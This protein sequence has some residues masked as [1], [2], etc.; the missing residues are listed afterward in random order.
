M[1]WTVRIGQDQTILVRAQSLSWND[2][3]ELKERRSLS[4]VAWWGGVVWTGGHRPDTCA[5]V[6]SA[7]N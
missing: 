3:K 5:G 4:T 2:C 1:G 6:R 7:L